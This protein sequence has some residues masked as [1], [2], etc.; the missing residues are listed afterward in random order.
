MGILFEDTETQ[1]EAP[2]APQSNSAAEKGDYTVLKR[3]LANIINSVNF[4]NIIDNINDEID[5]KGSF[6]VLSWNGLKVVF[7]AIILSV[8]ELPA[9]VNAFNAYKKGFFADPENITDL[10][11]DK[12]IAEALSKKGA[13][14]GTITEAYLG[15]DSGVVPSFVEALKSDAALRQDLIDIGKILTPPLRAREGEAVKIDNQQLLT[16]VL[17]LLSKPSLERARDSVVSSLFKEDFAKKIYDL[18][19]PV[20]KEQETKEEATIREAQERNRDTVGALLDSFKERDVFQKLS[21]GMKKHPDLQEK[22][23]EI[24]NIATDKNQPAPDVMLIAQK[25]VDTLGDPTLAD[26]RGAL[27]EALR[28]EDAHK[29]VTGN[30]R[31]AFAPAEPNPAVKGAQQIFV[32]R[33]M[34]ALPALLG[35]L[36]NVGDLSKVIESLRDK[37]NIMIWGGKVVD[38]ILNN[39][40]LKA[41]VINDPEKVSNL[42]VAL[43]HGPLKELSDSLKFDPEILDVV[44][45][46]S[47]DPDNVRKLLGSVEKGNNKE[48]FSSLNKIL[49]NDSETAKALREYLEKN[50]GFLEKVNR[51]VA[52]ITVDMLTNTSTILPEMLLDSE[53][54]NKF[55]DTQQA[56]KGQMEKLT[57]AIEISLQHPQS[58]ISQ[59]IKERFGEKNLPSL[60]KIRETFDLAESKKPEIRGWVCNLDTE[61]LN[62]ITNQLVKENAL[63]VEGEKSINQAVQVFNQEKDQLKQPLEG[64]INKISPTLLA[65]LEKHHENLQGILNSIDENSFTVLGA[66]DESVDVKQEKIQKDLKVIKGA[67]D[68]LK[69]NREL[70]DLIKDD[71]A[72]RNTFEKLFQNRFANIGKGGYDLGW[73]KEKIGI[74]AAQLAVKVLDTAEIFAQ[75]DK[76]KLI[77]DAYSAVVNSNYT[78]LGKAAIGIGYNSGVLNR[79]TAKALGSVVGALAYDA[80]AV[81]LEY[82]A[83]VASK[84]ATTT[85]NAAS[86]VVSQAANLLKTP[87]QMLAGQDGKEE[88]YEAFEEQTLETKK[89]V[90]SEELSALIGEDLFRSGKDSTRSEDMK[91]IRNHITEI[92]NGL[93]EDMVNKLAQ[94]NNEQMK[95]IVGTHS[96][97]VNK[98]VKMSPEQGNSLAQAYYTEATESTNMGYLT[99]G[100]R[101]KESALSDSGFKNKVENLIKDHEKTLEV[102]SRQH[103]SGMHI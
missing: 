74:D 8:K 79:D 12:N 25:A 16:K 71:T 3:N 13:E 27:K 31:A 51:F 101:V 14:L 50:P 54:L 96:G 65:T 88:F 49:L 47:K 95:Q 17:S 72:I 63:T 75:E 60:P 9:L 45:V 39:P 92:V 19:T 43:T 73:L 5:K 59:L 86:A 56:W 11:A 6:S 38:L 97:R 55:K 2:T 23:Q 83:A 46:A 42:L 32:E 93:D 64:L 103:S 33:V 70:R 82:A 44:K 85:L 1:L 34:E 69:D 48:L 30:I 20:K 58:K 76:F 36:D 28:A 40:E 99:G 80:G 24:I 68:Y 37:D 35:A 102:A 100:I 53:G 84:T 10:I 81:S 15:V 62:G 26:F 41:A 78:Q 67:L 4:Q 98:F 21:E 29:A 52:S 89:T 77:E 7:Q 57:E 18:M 66:R 94:L 90:I 91:L 61:T 87:M 22:L